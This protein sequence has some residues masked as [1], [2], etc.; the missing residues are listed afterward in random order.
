[1]QIVLPGALPE[2]PQA[3]ELSKHLSSAAPTLARWLAGGRAT[4]TPAPTADARCTPFEQWL[5]REQGFA[6]RGGQALASGLGPLWLKESTLPDAEDIWLAELTHIAPSRD[7]AVLIPAAQ[8]SITDAHSAALL[9]NAKLL[10]EGTGFIVHAHTTSRWR[11]SPPAGFAPSFA[12]PELVSITSV[13][14]WWTQQEDTRPWR[15]LFNELQM[16][17]FNHPVNDERA[18]QGLPPING[19][20]LFGGASRQQLSA[21]GAQE[22]A[23]YDA[24]YEYTVKQDWGGWIATLGHLEQTVFAPAGQSTPERLVLTGRERIVEITPDRRW[25]RK[26]L[27]PGRS[28]GKKRPLGGQQAEGAA[29]GRFFKPSSDNWSSWW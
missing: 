21:P 14:D 15:R 7:G 24:L 11:I 20:W 12:S 28:Q 1:M 2:Q 29:W 16:S 4:M 10:F 3:R 23:I 25:W 5:L 17:W 22:Y 19:L 18:Q 8:L 9:E 6:P 13:N 27:P 26:F